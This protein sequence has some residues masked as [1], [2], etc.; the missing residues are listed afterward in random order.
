MATYIPNATDAAEPVNSRP[1]GSA[2]EEFRTLK[3]SVNNRFAKTLSVPEA[4]VGALPNVATRANKLLGFDASGD[5]TPVIPSVGTLSG[6]KNRIINGKMDVAQRGTSFSFTVPGTSSA[7]SVDRWRIS[8]IS[9]AQTAV[10]QDSSD[11]PP[12]KEFRSAL[13]LAVTVADTS[14]AA[15]DQ[16]IIEQRIE[17][18]NVRDLIGVTFALSFWVKSS[19][20]GT[21]CVSFRNS[22]TDQSYVTTYTVN[23][24][25]TWEYKSV[26]VVNGLTTTGGWQWTN[27][28]GLVVSFALAA[29]TDYHAVAGAWQSAD[30]LATAAQ[31]NLLDSNTNTF[32]IT[33]VQLEAGTAATAFEHRAYGLELLLC[34]RYYELWAYTLPFYLISQYVLAGQIVAATIPF[35]VTKRSSTVS[36]SSSGINTNVSAT[37]VVAN[38]DF[39][40]YEL[41]ATATGMVQRYYTASGAPVFTASSEL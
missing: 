28:V 32:A 21:H 26:T 30:K 3:G 15:N 23:A 39:I 40:T 29:G 41:T 4:S 19:K 5:P 38:Q 31:V 22:T 8:Y 7:Y 14:I 33:G 34:Q 2:A 37:N 36:T 27:G 13:K 17:G 10:T 9:S 1:A 35:K 6:Y 18:Y 12:S 25:N 11:T 20:T 16:Y 24:A